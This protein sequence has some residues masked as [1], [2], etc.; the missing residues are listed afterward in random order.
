MVDAFREPEFPSPMPS[1]QPSV[2]IG[3]NLHLTPPTHLETPSYPPTYSSAPTMP[4]DPP[5]SSLFDPLG[6]PVTCDT[7]QPAG[8]VPDE[9]PPRQP[10]PP[11]G[12]PQ[13]ARRAPT[14]GTGGHKIG[15]PGSSM[16]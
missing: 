5:T 7:V 14:C 10:S 6:P 4:I 2:G 9:H 11:Q 8:D 16:V 13:R 12:R 1:S 3:I 15:R